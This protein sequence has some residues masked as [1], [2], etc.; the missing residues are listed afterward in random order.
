MRGWISKGQCQM[1]PAP[2]VI[3]HSGYKDLCGRC[4]PDLFEKISAEQKKRFLASGSV[5]E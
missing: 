2:V 4:D 3:A 5:H 1:C